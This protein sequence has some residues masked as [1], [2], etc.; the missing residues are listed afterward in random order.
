MVDMNMKLYGY[1]TMKD[2]TMI[3]LSVF[4]VSIVGYP[5]VLPPSCQF[6]SERIIQSQHLYHVYA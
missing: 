3:G 1:K 4:L 2:L 6:P 5:G